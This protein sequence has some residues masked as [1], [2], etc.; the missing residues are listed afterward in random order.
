M[1][2]VQYECVLKKQKPLQS[3]EWLPQIIYHYQ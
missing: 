2:I 1:F 3:M